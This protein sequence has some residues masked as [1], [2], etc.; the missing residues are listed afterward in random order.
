[1]LAI[2]DIVASKKLRTIQFFRSDHVEK[3]FGTS[4][5]AVRKNI[6]RGNFQA[7]KEGKAYW[8]PVEFGRF[9]RLNEL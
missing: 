4:A 7:Y 6:E 9:L 2:A 3:Q 8:I 1:M 5:D